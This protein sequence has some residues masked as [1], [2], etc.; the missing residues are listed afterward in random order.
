M[1]IIHSHISP[2]FL[3][4]KSWEYKKMLYQ[5]T[6]RK[7]RN[8]AWKFSKVREDDILQ[9]SGLSVLQ[10]IIAK[11]ATIFTTTLCLIMSIFTL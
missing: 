3:N 5:K 1:S 9:T 6:P 2:A 10:V 8:L 4:R 11:N 7:L